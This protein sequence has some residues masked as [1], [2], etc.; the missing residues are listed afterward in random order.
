[1]TRHSLSALAASAALFACT[2]G[3]L[4]ALLGILPGFPLLTYDS[5][6]ATSYNAGSAI[7]TITASPIAIRFSNVSPPRFV[8]PTGFPPSETLSI[9]V[10]LD[11]AGNLV[12]GIPGD[13]LLIVGQVDADG[14]GS[15]DY[16]GTLL[17]GEVDAFGFRDSGLTTDEYDFRF[18][19]TGGSLASLYGNNDIGV[20]VTSENSNFTGD[21]TVSFNGGAKGSVGPVPPPNRPPVCDANG[22]YDAEC[23]GGIT[24]VSLDGTLSSD[25]NGDPLTYS[26]STDCPGA[27]FDDASS[28]TPTL[29]ID[30]SSG[31]DITC[32]AT[33]T[34]SDGIHPP[35][36]CE[37]H[38]HI[39]D[40]NAPGITCPGMI[41]VACDGSTDPAHTGSPTATDDCD[42]APQVNYADEI[43]PGSCPQSWT[44]TRTWTA[45]DRCDL[46]ASCTQ[47]INVT[48]T[49]APTAVTCPP[50]ITVTCTQGTDPSVTGAPSVQD[51]CD[52]APTV[53]YTDESN[54]GNCPTFAIITRTWTAADACGNEAVVC[55]QTI[56][57]NDN[58]RP[59]I[60]CPPNKT[61]QCDE[62]KHPDHTGWATATDNC[63]TTPTITYCDSVCGTCPKIIERRWKAT[64]AC[65]N[66]SYCT[67]RI[68]IVDTVPPVITCPPNIQLECG[69]CV[70]T[71]P[72]VTGRPQVQDNCDPCPDVTYCDSREG[73]CPATIT[74]VWRARDRCGNSATC[75]QIITL[76]ANPPCPRTPG[77]WKT[78]R[79][80][81]PVDSLQVGAIVYNDTKLMNLLRGY[82]PNGAPANSDVSVVLAK[83]VVATKFNLLNGSDP[84]DIEAVVEAADQLL[85]TY[86]P[87]SNP[88][89]A[90][91]QEM[92]MLKDLLDA[93]ANSSPAGCS[94]D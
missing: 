32:S 88:R 38:V 85:S 60:C 65:G 2:A 12:G 36:A 9:N 46:S 67:Q 29:S 77:Y 47:I 72:A 50:D 7:F 17:T 16:S 51:N 28:P 48:D 30:T 66:Q 61:I 76:V 93:Y 14:N 24:S 54:P 80:R 44:V 15:I 79:N 18:R 33:L 6:G 42:P 55:V 58:S 56:Q 26:W 19:V 39:A 40:R 73:N 62:S 70:D 31:C 87:G 91:R 35:V 53:N 68:T 21:F 81:W 83:F 5:N 25:A 23:A 75:T 92:N 90:I 20:V 43:T 37:A 1:M 69:G 22:P 86:P 89:G 94:G 84:Q 34:V 45:T 71:S 74:R 41:D 52:P 63:G 3:T 4:A 11:A 59:V 82:K 49:A 8:N 10:E 27:T 64:D 78:H 57:V 13:D